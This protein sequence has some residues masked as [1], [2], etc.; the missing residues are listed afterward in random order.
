M[1]SLLGDFSLPQDGG[2]KSFF[3]LSLTFV[4][5]T[6]DNTEMKEGSSEA[7]SEMFRNFPFAFL[8]SLSLNKHHNI[9]THICKNDTLFACSEGDDD[10]PFSLCSVTCVKQQHSTYRIIIIITVAGLAYRRACV[11]AGARW[12]RQKKA[13]R[14]ASQ[15]QFEEKLKRR[16]GN[17]MNSRNSKLIVKAH[18]NFNFMAFGGAF[19]SGEFCVVQFN[20]TC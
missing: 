19:D 18:K 1:S 5:V 8:A 14:E 15:I 2:G 13:T 9:C 20:V 10:A 17:C 16:V 6:F 4:H 7:S 12:R 11:T 3:L